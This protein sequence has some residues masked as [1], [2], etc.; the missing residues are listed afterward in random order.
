LEVR[1]ERERLVT[2]IPFRSRSRLKRFGFDAAYLGRLRDGDSETERHFFA[3]FGELIL[4]KVRAR[5]RPY[6]IAED[7]RQETLLRVL[8]TL[9]SSGLRDPGSL[10]AFVN[11]VCNNVLLEQV[12]AQ[13]RHPQLHEEPPPLPDTST[14]SAEA[15]LITEERKRAVRD[16]IDDLPPNHRRLLRALYLEER[17]KAELCKELGVDGSY[18]RVLLHRAKKQFRV[19][20]LEREA[21]S[22]FPPD[23]PDDRPTAGC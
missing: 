12:R 11:S 22:P 3:Y 20:Y 2:I 4:I 9:R 1:G 7:V 16:V 14:P 18:L 13:G 17:D 6:L 21:G 8:R 15:R 23:A 10:G 5:R 19:R